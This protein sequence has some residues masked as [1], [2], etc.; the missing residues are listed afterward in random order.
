MIVDTIKRQTTDALKAG[1]MERTNTLRMLSS[2][3]YNAKI[4]KRR[5]L[6]DEEAV[7]VLQK[8]AK[9]RRD[10]IEIYKKARAMERVKSEEAELEVISEFL[11]KELTDEELAAIVGLSIKE[12]GAGSTS[13]FGRVM[14]SVVRKVGGGARGEQIARFVREAL[15]D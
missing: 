3:L 9:R 4:E 6:S 10:A 7:V 15:G 14:G 13:D 5:E 8:E 1:S 11:P 2:L 12:A